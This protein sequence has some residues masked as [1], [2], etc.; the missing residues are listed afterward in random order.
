[1]PPPSHRQHPESN[2]C[3]VGKYSRV[4][5]TVPPRRLAR[6]PDEYPVGDGA[7]I[8]R[9]REKSKTKIPPVSYEKVKN[10]LCDV[11][12]NGL[13]SGTLKRQ[14]N[15]AASKSSGVEVNRTAADDARAC[16][17]SPEIA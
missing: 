17:K 5:T 14:R 9:A 11:R 2:I 15:K 3:K 10:P 6:V 4:A 7:H 12:E 1:M 13:G 8:T 16:D